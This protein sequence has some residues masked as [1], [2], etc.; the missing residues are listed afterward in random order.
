[1]AGSQPDSKGQPTERRASYF[2]GGGIVADSIPDLELEETRWK[3]I[4]IESLAGLRPHPV[5]NSRIP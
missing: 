2:T 4:H 5:C 3:A 1:V